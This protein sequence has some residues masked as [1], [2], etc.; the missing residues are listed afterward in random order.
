[1]ESTLAKY[2]AEYKR[3]EAQLQK[4]EKEHVA[5]KKAVADEIRRALTLMRD[6]DIAMK[7]KL[8]EMNVYVEKRKG[9]CEKIKLLDS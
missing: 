3:L 4:E 1:M 2:E 7:K 8:D 5:Q 9:E 6:T